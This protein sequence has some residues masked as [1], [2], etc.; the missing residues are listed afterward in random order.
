M[1]SYEAE[2]DRKA[3]EYIDG[4]ACVGKGSV[5]APFDEQHN[6]DSFKAGADWAISESS[7]VKQIIEAVRHY[8]LWLEQ[9]N[10][11]N[12]SALHKALAAYNAEI[13]RK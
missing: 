10:L 4:D 2:R 8:S 9:N 13:N 5:Q 1:T 6:L 11:G 3:D 7:L 12:N